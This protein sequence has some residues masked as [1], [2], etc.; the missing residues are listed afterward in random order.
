[1]ADLKALLQ[2]AKSDSEEIDRTVKTIGKTK[3]AIE[4]LKKEGFAA[5]DAYVETFPDMTTSRIDANAKTITKLTGQLGDASL[6]LQKK[7]EDSK[8]TLDQLRKAKEGGFSDATSRKMMLDYAEEY[9]ISFLVVWAK[10]VVVIVATYLM[11]S[12]QNILYTLATM[13]AVVIVWYTWSFIVH[14]FTGRN[15]SGGDKPRKCP[16]GTEANATGSN[17]NTCPTVDNVPINLYMS[18][19][20]SVNG[21]CSNGMPSMHEDLK[22]CPV[23]RSCAASEFGCCPDGDTERT[24]RNGNNCDWT[25]YEGDCS[26]SKFGCCANGLLKEDEKG[27]NCTPANACGFSAF[28]CCPDG[29]DRDDLAGSN[30]A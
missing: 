30:C 25:Y 14:F 23:A 16:D 18:C 5:I 19:E 12:T 20:E 26:E 11:W 2:R 22:K 3:S 7:V 28:G 29:S 6:S 24:D 27:T 21:C 9:K 8:A 10:V 17:C 15:P 13:V 1:M 4:K